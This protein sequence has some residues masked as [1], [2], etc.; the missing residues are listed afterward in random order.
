MTPRFSGAFASLLKERG[1]HEAENENE[2]GEKS[3]GVAC[4]AQ[5]FGIVDGERA[6]K[7][8]ADEQSGPDVPA[9]P[10]TESQESQEHRKKKR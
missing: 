6:K 1:G 7:T 5:W 10:V 8:D 3:G 2:E 9:A 4:G